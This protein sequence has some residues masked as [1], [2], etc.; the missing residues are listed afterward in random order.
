M[1]HTHN[2][3]W[4]DYLR[5]L[6]RPLHSLPP[7]A[8]AEAQ[9]ELRQH[10]DALVAAQIELGATDEE[11]VRAALH[12]FGDPA[13]VGRRLAGEWRFQ[14]TQITIWAFLCCWMTRAVVGS[15]FTQW[16]SHIIDTR[17]SAEWNGAHFTAFRSVEEL[18]VVLVSSL[19]VGWFV[20]G[21]A[22]RVAF[23]TW[24]VFSGEP[25]VS[26]LAFVWHN[27]VSFHDGQFYQKIGSQTIEVPFLTPLLILLASFAVQCGVAY[28]VSAYRR[29]TFY[30]LRREDFRPPF[31]AVVR[32]QWARWK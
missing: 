25:Y 11:A 13:R 2:K 16:Q 10:L 15:L 27:V 4:D 1:F 31:W 20:P 14:H 19:V 17:P 28:L 29:E 26:L 3:E 5:R 9:Q 24:L 21:C 6:Y 7:D 12:L 8:R 30:T 22:F 18:C 23:Y 32:Q